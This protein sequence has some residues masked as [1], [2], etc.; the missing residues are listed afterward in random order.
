MHAMQTSRPQLA[1]RPTVARAL[2][3]ATRCQSGVSVRTPSGARLKLSKDTW[4]V[5]SSQGADLVVQ[6]PQVLAE[7]AKLE[8][9][10][11]RLYCTAL[12]G[13]PDDLLAPTAAWIDGSE[14]RPGVQYLVPPNAVLRF[15]TAAD[16]AAGYT[17][18]FEEQSGSDALAGMLLQGLASGASKEVQD[19]LREGQ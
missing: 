12:A 19:R 1:A 10:G 5:G 9:R 8:W 14:L 15:G 11:G 17:V 13:D 3:L 16:G 18:E 6:G 7:H 2:R 4:T